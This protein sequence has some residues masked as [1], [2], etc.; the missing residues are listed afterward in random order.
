LQSRLELGSSRHDSGYSYFTQGSGFDHVRWPPPVQVFDRRDPAL[1]SA[2]QKAG[3][4]RRASSFSGAADAS[5]FW[6][7]L[8]ASAARLSG[9]DR[10]GSLDYVLESVSRQTRR[11]WLGRPVIGEPSVHSKV[12]SVGGVRPVDRVGRRASRAQQMLRCSGLCLKLWDRLA[13]AAE[14]GHWITCLSQSRG[15]LDE[16]GWADQS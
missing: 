14:R 15:R 10:A 1:L 4:P 5:L 7:M 6:V 9:W 11:A 13:A 12:G 2:S 16:L 8:E 3:R